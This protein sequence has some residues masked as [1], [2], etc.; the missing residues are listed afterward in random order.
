MT[1]WRTPV[2]CGVQE[3][4]VDEVLDHLSDLKVLP[5]RC[6]VLGS[7]MNLLGALC[8]QWAGRVEIIVVFNPESI[9][10]LSEVAET[11]A[12]NE[13][14]EL[15]DLIWVCQEGQSLDAEPPLRLSI[16]AGHGDARDLAEQLSRSLHLP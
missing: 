1:R 13:G 14:L 9:G 4:R 3:S 7:S 2:F 10:N 8:T 6:L 12:I 15:T 11:I 16:S 5:D